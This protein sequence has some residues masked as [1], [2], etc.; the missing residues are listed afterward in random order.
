M[1]YAFS[2]HSLISPVYFLTVPLLGILTT[3]LSRKIKEI[4]KN[5]VAE[6]T[7]LAGRQPNRCATSS[8]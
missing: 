3:V 2:V 1:V 8:W 6:T 7:A 5:I 4:Q